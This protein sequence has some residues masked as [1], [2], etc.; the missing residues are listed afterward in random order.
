MKLLNKTNEYYIAVAIVILLIGSFVI[1][2]RILYLLNKEI[3]E[4]LVNEKSQ[5]EIQIAS[6]IQLADAGIVIGDR[7]E[8]TPLNKFHSFQVQL[9]DT[10][11]YDVYSERMVPYRQLSYEKLIN[12]K[13]YT[14]KILKR[15]PEVRHLFKGLLLT[16]GLTAVD[17]IFCFYFLNRWFS[18]K[19]WAP[20]YGAINTLKAFDLNTHTKLVFNKSGVDEFNDLN[21][22]L[23]R[24]T[25]RI[26]SD[27]NNLKEFTENASHEI[28]T[29][30][31]IIR[32][33]LE[34]LL[35]SELLNRD[36]LQN[37]KSSLDAVNRLSRLNKELILITRIENRQFAESSPFLLNDLIAEQ[38]H[39]L[40]AF[41]SRKKIT[42]VEQMY[43]PVPVKLN[44]NL[45]EILIS[46]L[47][48]NAIKYNEEGGKILIEMNPHYLVISNSGKPLQISPE[49][50]FERFLKDSH[51][52]SMGLGLAIVKKICDF[53]D[54]SIEYSYL[55]RDRMHSFLIMLT[56]QHARH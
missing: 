10:S 31:A 56:P 50:I 43:D 30:L 49:K 6:Q 18:R 40:D 36:H 47:L 25:E 42:V 44:R 7:I 14:I 8:I 9:K 15:L 26:A 29:P 28:Q 1:S 54:F 22:E 41:I 55:N 38:L 27:Y 46:N 37:I 16:V 48:T 19:V 24:L 34:L 4:R 35:Q 5:I 52:E 13:A 33:K 45:A 3:N 39:Q 23:T 51:S 11:R 21:E 53:Y 2:N 12:G 32:S 20:F 17:V